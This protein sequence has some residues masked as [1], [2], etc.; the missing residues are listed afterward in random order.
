MSQRKIS[1]IMPAYNVEKT[2]KKAAYSCVN[3]SLKDIELIIVDDCS[4]DST[5]DLMVEIKNEYPDKVKILFQEKNSRQGAARNKGYKEAEGKYIL[6]VDSDDWIELGACKVL[7]ECAMKNDY[8]DEVVG[9]LCENKEIKKFEN[10]E[11]IEIV[12][13]ITKGKYH[14]SEIPII[15][16]MMKLRK[17]L[18]IIEQCLLLEE[19]LV[20][21]MENN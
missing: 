16:D 15:K 7:Y 1:I 5:R 18:K 14:N 8:P 13:E 4:T 6:F 10:D 12:G 3:Q 21:S 9:F 17:W 11:W 2:I 20:K 19:L